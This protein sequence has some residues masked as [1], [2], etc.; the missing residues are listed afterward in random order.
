MNEYI[1]AICEEYKDEHIHGCNG[2]P[3]DECE[4][5]CDDCYLEMSEDFEESS[6][7]DLEEKFEALLEEGGYG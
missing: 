7:S 4:C 1:C 5:V 3:D 6:L 2:H